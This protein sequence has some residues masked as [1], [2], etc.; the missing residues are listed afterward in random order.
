VWDSF[1][2]A[3]A[4]LGLWH[5]W[6]KDKR[7]GFILCGLALGLGQYFYVTIRVLPL[8]LLL[9]AGVALWRDRET[10]K[11]RLPGL[12]LAAYVAFILFQP[13]GLLFV[14]HPDEFNAP[15]N[16]VTIFGDWMAVQVSGGQSPVLVVLNNIKAAA[17]GFTHLPLRLLYEANVPLLLTG[18][19][20]LFITG[21]LW[22]ITHFDLRY[23]LLV[24]P[25]VAAIVM[26]GLGQDPPAAQ[27]YFGNADGGGF[28]G[29]T[30]GFG[31]QMVVRIVARS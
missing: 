6:Q 4:V 9:W 10:F 29:T 21:L 25:M 1:F 15:M 30:L 23:L 14:Q 5:G 24:L 31:S 27:R 2:G 12:I 16:R 11:H 28:G 13:L 3:V 19:A 22:A 20:A 18:A 8:F 26:G 17:L 7:F